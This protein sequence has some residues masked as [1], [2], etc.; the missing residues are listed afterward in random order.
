MERWIVMA[1]LVAYPVLLAGIYF[2]LVRDN[3]AVTNYALLLLLDDSI[4]DT[5]RASVMELIRA[6]DAKDASELG[7]KARTLITKVA[8]R[9]LNN[10]TLHVNRLAW[11]LKSNT[12]PLADRTT[13]SK[14][15]AVNPE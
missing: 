12:Q 4:Y 2:I 11:T 5:Q 10:T 1:I 7:T 8:M 14:K 3:R 13:R 9:L 15:L 6:T